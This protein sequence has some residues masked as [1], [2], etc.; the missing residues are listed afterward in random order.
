MAPSMA[1]EPKALQ[2]E[3][4]RLKMLVAN[5]AL[6]IKILREAAKGTGE[7]RGGNVRQCPRF[8]IVL[9]PDRVSE[10]RACLGFET[11]DCPCA[12]PYSGAVW[13]G[14]GLMRA[15]SPGSSGA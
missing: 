9:G 2:Q 6:D 12:D 1:K 11:H 15:E 7:P 3:N 4:A 5:Q 8:V 14:G 13:N 10:P